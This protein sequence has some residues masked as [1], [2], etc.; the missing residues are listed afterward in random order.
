MVGNWRMLLKESLVLLGD[1]KD[2]ETNR[3][4]VPRGL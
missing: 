1:P 3:P 2:E 4:R